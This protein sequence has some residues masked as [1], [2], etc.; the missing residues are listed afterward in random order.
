MTDAVQPPEETK[1][2]LTEF[3]RGARAM[4][5]YF[6]IRAANNWHGNPKVQE[7]CAKENTLLLSWVEDALESVDPAIHAEWKTLQEATKSAYHQGYLDALATKQSHNAP[8]TTK[9]SVV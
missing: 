4:F 5:D 7:Q 3:Q 2:P 9:A 6:H 1:P 8:P